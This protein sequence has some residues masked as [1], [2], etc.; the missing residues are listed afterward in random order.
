MKKILSILFA[1]SLFVASWSNDN[2]YV[3]DF[4]P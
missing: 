1:N 2:I 4:N 3:K